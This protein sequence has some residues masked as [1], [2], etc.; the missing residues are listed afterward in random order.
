MAQTD[1]SDLVIEGLPF[2][3]EP[4]LC[5]VNTMRELELLWPAA[6][7]LMEA[8]PR[9][10]LD[11]LSL[12]EVLNLIQTDTYNLWVG[13][14]K[15]TVE[16]ALLTSFSRHTHSSPLYLVWG[17]GNGKKYW[18][19]GQKTLEH[20][21]QLIGATEIRVPGRRGVGRWAQRFG[22]LENQVVYV[23]KIPQPDLKWSH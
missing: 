17:G 14:S 16:V 4:K 15:K 13:I 12:E 21:A 20:F 10:L 5:R 8:H 2:H 23:K 22:Y 9:G 11:M 18:T 3:E 1:T 19:C 7:T 6:L